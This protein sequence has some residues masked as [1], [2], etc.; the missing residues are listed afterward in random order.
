MRQGVACGVVLGGLQCVV[1]YCEVHIQQGTEETPASSPWSLGPQRIRR[2]RCVST[3]PWH[4]PLG[5]TRPI[6]R[7]VSYK[8][9]VNTLPS[10]VYV[11]K[12]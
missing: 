2:K 12:F 5:W 1:W 7:P 10:I 3:V 9:L 4:V 11:F 6:V 8:D